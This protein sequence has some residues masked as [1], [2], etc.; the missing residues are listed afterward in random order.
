MAMLVFGVVSPISIHAP[1]EGSDLQHL[2]L[3]RRFII[4]IHAPREGSDLVL[5]H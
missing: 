4:S 1:R 3:I 2:G 5:V